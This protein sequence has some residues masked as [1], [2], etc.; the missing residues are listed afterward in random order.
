MPDLIYDS[1]DDEGMPLINNATSFYSP[2]LPDHSSDNSSSESDMPELIHVAKKH[3]IAF[4]GS[5]APP[6]PRS[7]LPT[8]INCNSKYLSLDFLPKSFTAQVQ[9]LIWILDTG[10]SSHMVPTTVNLTNTDT[11]PHN[12]QFGTTSTTSEVIGDAVFRS[13]YGADISLHN[14]LQVPGLPVGLVS[15][16]YLFKH[17]YFP[18]ISV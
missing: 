9:G 4:V 11:S 15:F 3:A 8:D 2:L 12:I 14:A 13:K 17:G 16:N 1:S 10:C 7:D 18:D 6:S 5:T